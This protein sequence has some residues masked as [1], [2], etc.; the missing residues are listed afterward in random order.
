MLKLQRLLLGG[1]GE[2]NI[3]V[4]FLAGLLVVV[5]AFVLAVEKRLV[6]AGSVR[7]LPSTRAGRLFG[8]GWRRFLTTAG[9]RVHARHVPPPGKPRK[10]R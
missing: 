1:V 3:A 6:L 7:M 2:Q 4:G 9:Q 8:G 10:W 5:L